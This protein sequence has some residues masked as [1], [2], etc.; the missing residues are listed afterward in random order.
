MERG[1]AADDSQLVFST[2]DTGTLNDALIINEIGNVGIGTASPSRPLSVQS[3]ATSIIADFKY[4]SAAY[5][6]IDLSNTVGAARISSV[7]NDLL[8]SP[9][10]NE[11]VR[12]ATSGSGRLVLCRNLVLVQTQ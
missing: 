6:S 9:G 8:L 12:Q 10:M 7:N 11:K 5:S 2:S 1:N 3:S 4:T